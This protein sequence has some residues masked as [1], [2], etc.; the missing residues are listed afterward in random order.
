MWRRPMAL[1]FVATALIAASY[2]HAAES[3]SLCIYDSRSFSEGASICIQ[4][5]FAI[6]CSLTA[7]RPVWKADNEVSHLCVQ[8][9]QWMSNERSNP[10]SRRH[11]ARQSLKKGD[12]P[13][14]GNADKCFNFGGKRYCE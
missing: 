10:K 14:L 12:E 6:T 3:V 1:A 11:S 5:R 2:T 8:S 7:D 13:L 9:S 4:R